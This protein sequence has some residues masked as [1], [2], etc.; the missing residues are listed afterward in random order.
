MINYVID[1]TGIEIG[2]PSN[3]FRSLIPVYFKAKSIDGV[4]FSNKTVWEGE[5]NAG[6][7][8]QYL[9][10]QF[11]NQFISDGTKLSEI[12]S[13]KYEFLLS[14]DCLEHIANPIKA[15]FEW[16]RILKLNHLMLLILPNKINN[17]DHKREFTT[18]EHIVHD[19]NN[20]TE[21]S[22]LTHLREILS[23]H[24][25]SKDPAAGD[26]EKFTIRSLDN[27]NNRCLHHHVFNENSIR[28]ILLMTGFSIIS[29]QETNTSLVIIAKK[30]N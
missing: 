13:E 17:F 5:I 16:N 25:L 12:P 18:F 27:F 22:D 9:P 4:N 8:Y 11:G 26:F 21:E 28:R 6:K 1:K 2:G 20:N 30:N 3:I 7:T 10:G 29:F 14:S 23:F 19:Y 24:D 15:L